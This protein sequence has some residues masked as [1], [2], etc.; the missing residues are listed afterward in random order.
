MKSEFPMTA[1]KTCGCSRPEHKVK[2]EGLQVFTSY[3]DKGYG[4]GKWVWPKL[5]YTSE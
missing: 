1:E 4:Y 2:I 3:G 5:K